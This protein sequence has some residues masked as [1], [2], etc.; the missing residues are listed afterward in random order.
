MKKILKIVTVVG[1]RPQFIKAAAV[2]RAFAE[3]NK[4]SDDVCFEEQIVHTGQHYDE[5]MSKVFFDQLK[6]PH[7][8]VNLEV[9]SGSHGRQS[10]LMLEK[11]ES[12]LLEN[13]PDWTLIYG[14][15][16][17]TLA[18]AL[19]AVKIHIPVAHVE[20]GLRSFNRRMPEEINRVVADHISEKLLC[21]TDTAVENLANEGITKGVHQV[22]DVMYDSVLFNMTLAEQSST[23]MD[24]LGLKEKSFYLATIHR[25]ENTDDKDR[26]D[27]I[28]NAL[29]QIDMPIL[30][31]IHPRTK[32]TLGAE[33]DKL[34]SRIKIIDPVSYLDM[35]IL[36]K[37]S[38]VIL[39]DSGGVQKEAYWANVPCVTLRDE[40]EWTELV[41][42]GC[43][44]VVGSD[45]SAIMDAVEKAENEA[46]Q[47][48]ACDVSDLYGDGHSADKIATVLG[49]QGD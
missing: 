14:D 26:M 32:N 21:P 44:R 6:I 38:R 42:A 28:L 45:T 4:Q 47:G 49:E 30:L 46:A 35:L 11:I 24:Q 36:E 7:P 20:S 5:N 23:I 8:S 37:N 15:T 27:G 17:S 10:G 39:T 33:I 9:G 2:S 16:N 29:S 25:A 1:A 18:A 13:K 19:A 22:G 40:T 31:P 34:G 3:F 12:I 43:N 41:T 48:F